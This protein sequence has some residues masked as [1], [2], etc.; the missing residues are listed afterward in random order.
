MKI[1]KIG[2]VGQGAIGSLLA[3]YYKDL[4]PLLLV[5]DVTSPAKSIVDINGH[6]K[7]LDFAKLSIQQPFSDNTHSFFDCIVISVKGYQLKQLI[8][9]LQPWLTSSTRLILIQNGMGGAQMLAQAFPTNSIYVGTTTDAVYANAK[10]SYQVSAQGRVDLGPFSHAPLALQLLPSPANNKADET[11][12]EQRWIHTF[13]SFHPNGIY[14]QDV[15]PALYKKLA[16]NAVINPLTAILQIKNG[17]LREYP[18]ETAALKQ[19][20]F[21]IYTAHKL[22]FCPQVLSDAIDSVI[23]NTA[24]NWS[25]MCQDVKHTRLTENETVLGHLLKMAEVDNIDTPIITQLYQQIA[26]H[27]ALIP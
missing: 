3:Y 12:Q 18:Q 4:S 25:S 1:G 21:A 13:L 11:L 20:V 7:L 10:D 19:E 14:H 27:D 2:I 17:E 26:A 24:G 22:T 6:K 16:I 9:H 15:L 5:K 8:L 23:E